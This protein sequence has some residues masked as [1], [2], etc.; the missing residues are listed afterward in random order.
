MIKL[1]EVT[2]HDFLDRKTVRE[3]LDVGV[4][5]SDATY[6]IY[7]NP[8]TGEDFIGYW[9]QM[10]V[11]H[12]NN[13]MPTYTIAQLHFKLHEHIYPTINGIEYS[14]GLRYFKD[15]PFYVFYYDLKDKDGER[16]P[17]VDG[18]FAEGE[19]PIISLAYLLKQ[20]H[21]KHTG[22]NRKD[23]KPVDDVGSI[24]TKYEEYIWR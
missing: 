17:E 1:D 5:M 20:C 3:L 9:R 23:G 4:D 24:R 11:E 19:T 12:A 18:I 2:K 10:D 7:T 22:Y 6:Y 15:A 13:C 21:L 8:E 14:G 16:C